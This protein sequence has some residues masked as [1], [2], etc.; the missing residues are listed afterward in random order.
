MI[1]IVG[2][3]LSLFLSLI[4]SLFFIKEKNYLIVSFLL[5]II[6]CFFDEISNKDHKE[7][8]KKINQ[9]SSII[10]CVFCVSVGFF[11]SL[12]FFIPSLCFDLGQKKNKINFIFTV[13]SFVMIFA[14]NSTLQTLLIFSISTLN[15]FA[16][17]L[18][19]RI[20]NLE[21]NLESEKDKK[22]ESDIIVKMQFKEL[23]KAQDENILSATLKERN[24]IAR[25]MHDHVGHMLTRAILQSAAINV[26]NKD[27][28]L[29][30]PLEDLK[31]TLDTTMKNIRSSVHDLHDES[32][33][34]QS[35]IQ[36]LV[37]NVDA[38]KINFRYDIKKDCKKE[39]KYAF[40]AITKEA[41]TNAE[42][43]SN[44]NSMEILVRE[45]PAFFQL[46]IRDNGTNIQLNS[47]GIGLQNMKDRIQNLG[48]I[49]Q[50][51]TDKGFCINATVMKE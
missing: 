6:V 7:S 51:N 40:I 17:F 19:Q 48:G 47:T 30:N 49:I 23:A 42:K 2:K 33:N 15:F 31:S 13:L 18:C 12:C 4:L 14:R 16:G 35:S 22:N 11:P 10:Q 25:E 32:I 46:S 43:Y 36:N 44:C 24:R 39:I 9:F 27:E 1:S 37:E 38:F 3:T 34:L 45:H 20:F 41:I 50:I 26:L 8:N 28:N 29:K 21:K 5:A